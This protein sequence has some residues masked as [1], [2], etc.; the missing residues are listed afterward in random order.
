MYIL[1]W[2][3]QWFYDNHDEELNY[4]SDIKIEALDNP[5][6]TVEIDLIGTKYE[7]MFNLKM[8][9]DKGDDDWIVCSINR[10]GFKGAGDSYKLSEIIEV[11]RRWIE[12]E[13]S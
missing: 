8:E 9:E 4:I 11:F 7:N 1:E 6:W 13:V 12:Q 2:L 5:G 10:S 3:Q